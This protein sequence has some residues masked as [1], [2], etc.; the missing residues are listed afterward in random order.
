MNEILGSDRE[1]PRHSECEQVLKET[2]RRFLTKMRAL[3]TRH[4]PTNG[5]LR[6]IV[7]D[8]ESLDFSKYDRDGC[9]SSSLDFVPLI[10]SFPL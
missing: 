4:R 9:G 6:G 10:S 2:A 5:R 1:I 8:P 3:M 7:V